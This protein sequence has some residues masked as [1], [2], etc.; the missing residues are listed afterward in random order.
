MHAFEQTSPTVFG[1][2]LIF[3]RFRAKFVSKHDALFLRER[4]SNSRPELAPMG[5]GRCCVSLRSRELGEQRT[6]LGTGYVLSALVHG[7]SGGHCV[8]DSIRSRADSRKVCSS[9]YSTSSRL[10]DFRR[11]RYFIRRVYFWKNLLVS[12]VNGASK[13]SYKKRGQ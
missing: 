1:F 3:R 12:T 8:S 5:D 2:R 7:R 13:P 4:R 9:L 10:R 6:V 11:R